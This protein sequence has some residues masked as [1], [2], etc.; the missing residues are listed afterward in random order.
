MKIIP[1]SIWY[2]RLETVDGQV[3]ISLLYYCT[4]NDQ[5]KGAVYQVIEKYIFNCNYHTKN[6]VVQLQ[7]DVSM[8]MFTNEKELLLTPKYQ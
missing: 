8:I 4:S 6:K 3:K 7:L 1:S 5:M 2:W